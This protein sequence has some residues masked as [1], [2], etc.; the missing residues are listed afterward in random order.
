MVGEGVNDAPA[1]APAAFGIPMG[2][3]G[4]D[5]AIEAHDMALVVDC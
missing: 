4:T 2:S 3:A 5:A 1:L